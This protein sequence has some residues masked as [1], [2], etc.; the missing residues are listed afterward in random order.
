M[1]SR[2]GRNADNDRNPSFWDDLSSAPLLEP[3]EAQEVER[4]FAGRLFGDYYQHLGS[5]IILN[6]AV[7]LQVLVGLMVGGALGLGFLG[8]SIS[9]IA[10][11]AVV[12]VLFAGPAFAGIFNFARVMSDENEFTRMSAYVTGMR[13]Y[14]TR[15]WILLAAQAASGGIIFLA[16]RFYVNMHNLAG[17]VALF[18]MLVLAAVW[19]MAGAY[20]WPL[21][22][23]DLSWQH[24]VRNAVFLAL[25]APLG[26]AIMVVVLTL[27]SAVL[28]IVPI[29][30]AACLF[31]AWAVTENVA[32]MRLVRIIRAR[33]QDDSGEPDAEPES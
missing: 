2:S 30:A 31:S 24:L 21:L 12:V 13:T 23:R 25:S 29:L 7:V 15:S 22:V 33:Q 20:A 10:V 8:K 32:L 17:T 11:V 26:T 3:T 4:S 28:I 27:L 14:A 6:F 16:L 19:G 9:G 1:D 18:I 5:L